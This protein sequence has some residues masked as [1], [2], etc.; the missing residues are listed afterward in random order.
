[1]S[2]HDRPVE[3]YRD[4]LA[5]FVEDD[6]IDLVEAY[7]WGRS[8][9]A[10]G[11]TILDVV[12]AHSRAMAEYLRHHD[13]NE[14]AGLERVLAVAG[15]ALAPYE[16]AYRGF[17][18]ANAALVETNRRLE[19]SAAELE[20]AKTE[21]VEA[22]RAKSDFLSRMSHELRTPLNSIIG[23]AQLLEFSDLPPDD[24]ESVAMIL[25][26]GRHLLELINEVLDIAR[27]EAG[28]M[29][30]SLEPVSVA[31]VV[32][33]A[34]ELMR[35]IAIGAGVTLK[36]DPTPDQLHVMADHQR[37]TQVLIN[38]VSNAVKYNR[39]E[40]LVTVSCGY[41][42]ET[43]RINVTDTGP[44]LSE[45]HLQ[46]LF[47]PFDR[48]GAEQ[49]SIEGTGLGLALSQRLTQAM[50]GVLSVESQVGEGSTFTLELATVQADHIQAEV[51]ARLARLPDRLGHR[52]A[53]VLYV[54][55]N[56]SNILLVG[57]V[58]KHRPRV[59]LLFTQQGQLGI[60]LAA[61]HLPDLILLDLDLPD[62]PGHEV[63]RRLRGDRRTAAVPIVVVSADAT[64]GQVKALL[65]DGANAYLTKPI[66]VLELLDVV[67]RH[68]EGA[69]S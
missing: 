61:S 19:A 25:K 60:E 10:A 24:A 27:I 67:D 46:R 36:V 64:P 23:F 63:L 68:V 2:D 47:V 35:P 65:G 18:Q 40:G 49:S 59:R 43:T 55:D 13:G 12:D 15:E 20:T 52:E 4:L 8:V 58:L 34:V 53:T 5:R 22:N 66:D 44:G 31:S 42:D 29:T 56:R 3:T 21:A 41:D 6:R 69:G 50:G 16:M 62:M 54:E 45:H 30:I 32:G 48:L 57:R 28:R 38:L 51:D 17:R 9:M 1:M 7:E 39:N 26:G 33:S 11:A 14:E 37:I